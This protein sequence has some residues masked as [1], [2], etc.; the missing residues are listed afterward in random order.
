MMIY[1]PQ[2]NEHG[3]KACVCGEVDKGL[4]HR[5]APRASS[6]SGLPVLPMVATPAV[7]GVMVAVMAADADTDA[8]NV[9]A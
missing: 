6:A 1:H 4:D 7:T 9:N 2:A 3:Q 8:A 5:T